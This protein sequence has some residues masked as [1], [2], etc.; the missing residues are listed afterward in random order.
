MVET[1]NVGEEGL[2]IAR[3]TRPDVIV[4]DL[5][6][7]GMGGLRT[8]SLLRDQLSDARIIAVTPCDTKS[9]KVTARECGADRLVLGSL[10]DRDLV[11]AIRR[12]M[13]SR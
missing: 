2:K 9:A 10:Q 3:D 8:I 12:A 11:Q 7:A 1:V 5:G 13:L 4:V 6:S